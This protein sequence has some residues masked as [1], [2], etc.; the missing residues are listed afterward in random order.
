MDQEEP[1]CG[2]RDRDASRSDQVRHRRRQRKNQDSRSPADENDGC[3]FHQLRESLLNPG[4]R[5]ATGYGL[6]T[7][8]LRDGRTLRGFARSRTRFH[9]AVQDLNGRLH[10]LSLDEVTNITE[11]K[12]SLM[13]PLKASTGEVQNVIA[14]DQLA[15]RGVLLVQKAGVTEADEKLAASR[16]RML[17]T[18]HG[19]HAAHMGLV[20]ELSLELFARAAGAPAFFHAGVFGQRIAALDHEAFDD[21]MKRGAIVEAFA[22][23]FLEILDGLGRDVRPEFHHHVACRGFDDCNF[24]RAHN[25]I[26]G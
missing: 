10:P 9:I 17:R 20:V 4:A 22:R 1:A 26:W 6:V 23:K 13:P 25:I 15:E 18:R 14:F 12:T 21:A 8:Q 2:A 11:E 3:R 5:I 16:I 24:V 19:K 7:L